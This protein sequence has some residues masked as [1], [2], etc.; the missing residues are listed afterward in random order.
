LNTVASCYACNNFKD[1][2]TPEE[3]GMTLH[4]KPFVPMKSDLISTGFS[5]RLADA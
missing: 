3:A 5:R 4:I 1:D 2:R